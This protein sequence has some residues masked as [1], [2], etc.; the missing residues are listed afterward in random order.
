MCCKVGGAARGAKALLEEKRGAKLRP[1]L[2][3]VTR[4]APMTVDCSRAVEL[5]FCSACTDHAKSEDAL[6]L[7]DQPELMH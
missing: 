1:H 3:C 7:C 6:V 5:S 4:L 2:A